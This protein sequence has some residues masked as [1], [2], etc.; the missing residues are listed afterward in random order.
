MNPNDQ[1]WI[2]YVNQVLFDAMTGATYPLYSAAFQKWFGEVPA[3]PA[4][5]MPSIFRAR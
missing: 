4:I 1:V 3:T 2:N 5:G